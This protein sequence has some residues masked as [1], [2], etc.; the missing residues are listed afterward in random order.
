MT[1]PRS[2]ALSIFERWAA[3]VASLYRD[4]SQVSVGRWIPVHFAERSGIMQ[5]ILHDFL[6]GTLMNLIPAISIDITFLNR[7][8]SLL[9]PNYLSRCYMATFTAFTLP[10]CVRLSRSMRRRDCQLAQAEMQGQAEHE[11]LEIA[12]AKQTF[13]LEFS[14]S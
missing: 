4:I 6:L 9:F 13:E 1:K 7:W 2:C 3:Q 11:N 5:R 14:L 10:T 8:I 12:A